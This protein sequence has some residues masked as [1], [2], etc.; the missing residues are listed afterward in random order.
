MCTLTAHTMQWHKFG[1]QSPISTHIMFASEI[2]QA[3]SRWGGTTVGLS[4]VAIGA[5]GLLDL[6]KDHMEAAAQAAQPRPAM[7]GRWH[8]DMCSGFGA[9]QPQGSFCRRLDAC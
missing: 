1:F 8:S 5:L 3:L 2:R 6:W 4:L 7:E 9:R